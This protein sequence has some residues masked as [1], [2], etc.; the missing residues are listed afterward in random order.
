[1]SNTYD[2]ILRFGA[3]TSLTVFGINADKNFQPVNIYKPN[4]NR[5]NS[6]NGLDWQKYEIAV[7]YFASQGVPETLAKTYGM[8]ILETAKKKGISI[9]ELIHS[10]EIEKNDYS[11]IE[12][13]NQQ[14]PEISKIGIRK[15]NNEIPRFVLR[16]IL[17]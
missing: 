17:P 6:I 1:M 11:A 12:Y 10:K 7:S 2:R 15:D 4:L 13:I 5:N 8:A 9:S 14:R 3:D 16:N